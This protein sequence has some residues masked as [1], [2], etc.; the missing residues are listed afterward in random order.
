MKK[1]IALLAAMAMC[2]SVL[3]AYAETGEWTEVNTSE[4]FIAA[5]ANNGNIRVTGDITLEK[6]TTITSNVTIDLNDHTITTASNAPLNIRGGHVDLIGPGTITEG[7]AYYS[8]FMLYGANES[9]ETDYSYLKVGSDVTL[10]G[11]AGIFIDNNNH[12]AYGVKVDIY[13]TVKMTR[14]YTGA[15][16]SGIYVNGNIT[17]TDN[18]PVINVYDGAIID[19]TEGLIIYG[20]GYAE[21]NIWGGTL[22]SGS[23]IEMRAGTLNMYGGNISVTDTPA[24]NPNGNGSTTKGAGIAVSQHTTNLP[25]NVNICGG[26]ITSENGYALYE[27]DLQDTEA[28]DKINIT[29]SGGTFNGGNGYDAIAFNDKYAITY[30][31]TGGTFN[32]DV[33]GYVGTDYSVINAGGMYEVAKLSAATAGQVT[34]DDNNKNDVEAAMNNAGFT[35]DEGSLYRLDAA[36]INDY[37]GNA[38]FAAYTFGSTPYTLKFETANFENANVKLGIVLYNIPETTDITG[39]SIYIQ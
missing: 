26:V 12:T 18:S 21:W 4:G 35:G 20:A 10:I 33:S 7:K 9:T 23:G 38:I 6:G 2:L 34:I 25:I 1:L 27:N 28:L 8:P 5:L 14:D 19:S 36:E 24:Q 3:P 30:S 31:V 39:P 13:G 17:N 15:L 22:R 29:I 11:W 37:S 16:G 32:T